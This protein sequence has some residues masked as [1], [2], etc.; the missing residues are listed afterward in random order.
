MAKDFRTD[1]SH[2]Q[3]SGPTSRPKLRVLIVDDD[4]DFRNSTATLLTLW[5]FEAVAAESATEALQVTERFTPDL[6]LLDI[7]MPGTDG[8]E[9]ANR[10]REQAAVHAKRPLLVAVSGYGDAETRRR[11][12]EAGIDLHLTKPVDPGQLETLL[13]RFQGVLGPEV[14]GG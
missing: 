3:S 5:G 12:Q 6:V 2:P 10:L 4:A 14:A 13:R 11:S 9:L 7:G 8:L 1:A